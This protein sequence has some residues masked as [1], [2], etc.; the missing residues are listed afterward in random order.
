ME[1]RCRDL[2]CLLI[3]T[4]NSLWS[5]LP[6]LY[7]LFDYQPVRTNRNTSYY[8]QMTSIVHK[9]FPESE[10][11]RMINETRAM[12]YH[13]YNNYMRHA[14]PHDELDPIHCS[15]RGHDWNDPSNININDALGDYSLTLIDALSTLVVMGDS[16]RFMEAVEYISH[17]ITFDHC[18]TVQVFEA[19]IRVIGS[20]LS[21]HLIITEADKRLGDFRPLHYSDELLHVAHDLAERLLPAFENTATGL[22]HPRVN[23]CHGVPSGGVPET[24]TAGA[25]SLILEFSILSRL[26]GDPIYE[27]LARR[28]VRTLWDLRHPRTGLVGNVVNI[29]S[30]D[31][32]GPMSGIGA[33]VDSFYEYLLK[34][35]ILFG[36]R[37]DLEMFT[38][39]YKN[40]MKYMRKG[41]CSCLDIIINDKW[42]QSPLYVN[43]NYNSGKLYNFWFDSLSASF[44][45]LQ[46]LAGDLDEAICTHALYYTLWRKY[47]SLPERYD[48]KAKSPS[49]SFYPLRPELAESTYLLYQATHNPFYLHVGTDILNSI[50]KHMKAKCGYATLHDVI[51]KEKE[52]RMESFFLSEMCKYLYLLFDTDHVINK[53]SANY[54]FTTE[55][56]VIPISSTLHRKQWEEESGHGQCRNYYRGRSMSRINETML[57]TSCNVYS[58]I[59]RHSLP[60]V[61]EHFTELENFIGLHDHR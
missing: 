50:N 42:L 20:L 56:H 32:I 16:E 41:C 36:E 11:L 30:G 53:H 49:V 26:V 34:S 22:P 7:M 23:L 29:H 15:G 25:G 3:V 12:F 55:G 40:I 37:E 27:N 21:S 59:R 9:S 2:L 48:W 33:G 61:K 60:L 5:I 1:L 13:G 39:F 24:C 57:S 44:A 4:M 58:N 52:D 10:R 35:F 8:V 47:E 28:A 43:V 45:G 6:H 46:V 31:W 19:N 14:F 51:T 17:N 54:L 18:P 38:E